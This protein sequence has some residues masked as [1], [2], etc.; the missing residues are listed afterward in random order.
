MDDLLD[1]YNVPTHDAIF[2]LDK[3]GSA[4]FVANCA[5]VESA[6]KENAPQDCYRGETGQSR[7]HGPVRVWERRFSRGVALHVFQRVF[8]GASY[9]R[10]HLIEKKN[11]L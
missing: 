10:A 2:F 3:T 1:G 8:R 4:K 6:R 5:G 11:D 7:G 9:W